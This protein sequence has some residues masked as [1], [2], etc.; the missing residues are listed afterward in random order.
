MSSRHGIV[1]HP[2]IFNSETGYKPES[3]AFSFPYIHQG[4]KGRKTVK[5][6][7]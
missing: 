6:E 4:L 2:P 3:G 5:K 7:G 1:P